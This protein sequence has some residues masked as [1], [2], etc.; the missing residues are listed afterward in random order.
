MKTDTRER[1]TLVSK[2]DLEVSYFCGPGPGGQKRNKAATGVQIRHPASGAV[3]KASDSRSQHDNK[4]NAFKRLREHPRMKIF[5]SK[6]LFELR[7][8]ET[9]EAAI[10][11]ETT[12][13]TLKLEIK[14]AKGQWE[15]VDDAYFDS[16]AARE[17][18][19]P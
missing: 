12:P 9:I 18:T 2:K 1:V 6:K 16:P 5:L 17:Q 8:Q 11:R 4:V 13:D 15:E 10:E 19:Q 14:N 7:E 3:A